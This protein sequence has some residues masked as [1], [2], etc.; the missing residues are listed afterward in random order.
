MKRIVIDKL[1]IN[2]GI[3]KPGEPLEKAEKLLKKMFP[4]RKPVR[5]K[6]KKRIESWGIRPGLEIGVKLTLRKKEAEETLKW[7][8]KAVNNTLKESQFDSLGNFS[9]GIKEYVWIPGL[10]YDPELGMIGMDVCVT[11]KRP[12]YRV[13]IRKIKR[14][15]IPKRHK[16]TKEEVIKFL[17]ENFKVKILRE[18]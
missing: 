13:M 5:T 8:L 4:N 16:T 15:S 10:K 17:E 14:S 7:L 6:A 18:A 9:F 2:I 11:V 3:G 1:T 12:G